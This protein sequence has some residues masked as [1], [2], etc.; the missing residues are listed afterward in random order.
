VE[1]GEVGGAAEDRKVSVTA[2]VVNIDPH[3][4]SGALAQRDQLSGLATQREGWWRCSIL[5]TTTM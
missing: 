2:T 1:I 5:L 3:F 4:Q